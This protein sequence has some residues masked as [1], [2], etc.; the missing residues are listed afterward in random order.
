MTVV[1]K[2]PRKTAEKLKLLQEDDY[3]KEQ[4]ISQAAYARHLNVTRQA[5]G[6]YIEQRKITLLSN[7][8]IDVEAADKELA[9]GDDPSFTRRS[10]APEG[11]ISLD[12]KEISFHEEKAKEKKFQAGIVELKYLEKNG[13]LTSKD[14]MEKTAYECA[15]M[16]RD[17]LKRVPGKAITQLLST[18]GIDASVANIKKGQTA[19]AGEINTAIE[20]V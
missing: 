16:L 6:K 8:N 9:A 10:K 19:L 1:M 14:E 11:L 3:I 17:S 12:G 13:E 20:G 5:V 15:R 4:G 2:K 7:G 18:F